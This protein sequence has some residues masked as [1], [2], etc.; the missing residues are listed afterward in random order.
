[1]NKQN[2]KMNMISNIMVNVC[3]AKLLRTSLHTFKM[4]INKTQFTILF[5]GKKTTQIILPQFL[6]LA[7]HMLTTGV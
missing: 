4:N 6:Q 7:A 5:L 1:M 3:P 2:R